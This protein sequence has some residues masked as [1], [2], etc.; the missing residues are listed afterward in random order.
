MVPGILCYMNIWTLNISKEWM[1]SKNSFS[2]WALKRPE[3]SDLL[4]LTSCTLHF[5]LCRS[6]NGVWITGIP[7]RK[8]CTP[9]T[10]LRGN[11]G[12]SCGPRA[13]IERYFLW[14]F[15]HQTGAVRVSPAE[16]TGQLI[17][18]VWSGQETEDR[19]YKKKYG[20]IAL[21]IFSNKNENFTFS[22][23]V[24]IQQILICII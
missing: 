11:S 6:L 18:S 5:C 8:P 19:Q 1:S 10:L 9:I 4:L 13:G 24:S 3:G 15:T 21:Y 14:P 16:D 22:F 7:R 12:R 17:R 20:S 2:G 23:T